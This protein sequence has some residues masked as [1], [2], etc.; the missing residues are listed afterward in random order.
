MDLEGQNK[1]EVLRKVLGH[2][3]LLLRGQCFGEAAALAW[4]DSPPAEVP[5]LLF[6]FWSPVTF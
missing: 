2:G 4:L 6:C 3:A 5:I 1:F